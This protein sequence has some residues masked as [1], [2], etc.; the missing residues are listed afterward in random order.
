MKVVA[1]SSTPRKAV[2]SA[3]SS[4]RF[5]RNSYSDLCLRVDQGYV[6]LYDTED[7]D[8]PEFM[9]TPEEGPTYEYPLEPEGA[10]FTIT[11][12]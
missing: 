11:S 2:F 6:V 9:E 12:M 1:N 7:G 8:S 4:G 10:Q 3:I 5:F